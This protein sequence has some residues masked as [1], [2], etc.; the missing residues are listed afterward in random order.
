[1]SRL[2]ALPPSTAEIQRAI[3]VGWSGCQL[4]IDRVPGVVLADVVTHDPDGVPWMPR[5]HAV[6]QVWGGAGRD[7]W[8]AVHDAAPR[9]GIL[10]VLQVWPV[11]RWA[12]ARAWWR[13]LT[14]PVV[15]WL[16]RRGR[17]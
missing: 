4:G 7:V 6:V 2:P 9:L 14:W 16:E 8:R 5:G 11:T 13:V 1:M 15:R 10:A 17:A 12:R 3:A